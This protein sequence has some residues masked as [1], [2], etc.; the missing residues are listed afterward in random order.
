MEIKFKCK[1]CGKEWQT[2]MPSIFDKLQI[3]GGL[4]RAYLALEV[5]CLNC[6]NKKVKAW[7]KVYHRNKCRNGGGV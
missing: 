2:E 7:V 1:K 3:I 5:E 4:R 6:G